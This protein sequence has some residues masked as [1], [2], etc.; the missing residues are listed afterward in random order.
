MARLWDLKTG[1]EVDPRPG[2]RGEYADLAVSP[3]DGSVFT[4]GT[5]D[6]VVLRWDAATG[7]CLEIVAELPAAILAFDVAP[8]GKSLLIDTWDGMLLWDIAARREVRRFTGKREAHTGFYCASFSPDGRTVTMEH[9]VW[10]TAT[11]RLIAAFPAP[12]NDWPVSRSFM[13]VRYS[14]DGRRLI[15]IESPGVAHSG[16]RNWS[17]AEPAGPHPIRR[18]HRRGDLARWPPGDCGQ[19]CPIVCGGRQPAPVGPDDPDLRAG[20]G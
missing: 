10:E 19:L 3:F 14:P 2:H 1:R 4:A 7:R 15:S 11:G 5:W 12:K 16:Y 18:S 20:L 8:D 6:H 13:S 9:R 17:R